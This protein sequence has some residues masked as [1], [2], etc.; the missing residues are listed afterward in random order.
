MGVQ[1]VMVMAVGEEVE[2]EVE[3]GL[4]GEEVVVEV[5]VEQQ[6]RRWMDWRQQVGRYLVYQWCLRRRR[7]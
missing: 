3:V 7:Y 1:Q 5:V 4:E 2:E 6:M